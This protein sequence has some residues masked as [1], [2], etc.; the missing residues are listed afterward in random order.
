MKTLLFLSL[1]LT[2]GCSKNDPLTNSSGDNSTPT[3]PDADISFAA[4]TASNQTLYA[5]E[6]PSTVSFATKD[7]WTSSISASWVTISPDHGDAAGAYTIT[8][9]LQPNT[10]GA[11]RSAKIA[12]SCDGTTITVNITQK[13]VNKDG[14]AY[15]PN[16][17]KS[18]DVYVAGYEYSGKIVAILWKNGVAQNLTDGSNDAN[19]N[20]VLVSGSDVYVAGMDNGSAILWKNGVEQKLN[21]T[22]AYS[23]FVFG[24]DVYV[25]GTRDILNNSRVILWKNGVEQNFDNGTYQGVY[26]SS[27]FVTGND[28]YV[29]GTIL[30]NNGNYAFMYAVLWKNGVSQVFN[31]FYVNSAAAY[32]VFVSGSDVYVAG[33]YGKFAVLWKNGVEQQLTNGTNSASANSVYVSGN[34][35]YVSGNDGNFAV[36]WK[37]GVEQKLTN[38]TIQAHAESVFVNGND[39]YVA[40]NDGNFAVLWKNDVEQKLTDGTIYTWASSVFVVK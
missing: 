33:A 21:G 5:D 40:G 25:A 28:V 37:N 14:T 1:L 20:F 31:D 17:P 19:A 35:V 3:K 34:D 2:F 13:A 26:V 15:N 22:N 30:I 7:A 9:G 24:S 16:A 36:L 23:V 4:G 18:G 38:G 10:T 29:S 6:I 12:I 27:L 11:D 32:S 8:I 39:V